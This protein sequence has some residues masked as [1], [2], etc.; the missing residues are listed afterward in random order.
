MKGKI[1]AGAAAAVVALAV[2][3]VKPW[4]GYEP[5]PYRDIV[6]VLTVCYGETRDI[7]PRTYS[8]AECEAKLNSRL[9]QYL[10]ELSN[11]VGVPL[12][13]HE[14]AALLSWSYNVGTTAACKSTLIRKVN[15]GAAPA[16]F[17]AELKKW[18]YAGGK[19]VRGLVNRREAE[20]RM[21]MGADL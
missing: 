1:A 4:E 19:R 5:E 14:W 17:C 16:E 12:R 9:G 7:Q 15:S 2:T 20:Y 8:Q 10:M 3:L 18:V 11:C 6:G 21:C 13:R